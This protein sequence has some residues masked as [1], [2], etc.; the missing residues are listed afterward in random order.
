MTA[1]P[2]PVVSGSV[3][4]FRAWRVKDWQLYGTGVNRAW[5]PGVNEATC[6]PGD[7][8]LLRRYTA[9]SSHAAPHPEC[10]C[11]ITALARFQTADTHWREDHVRGAIEAWGD[12]NGEDTGFVL[13]S[14]GFRARYGRAVLLAIDPEWPPAKK[15]AVR[16]LAAEYAADVCRIE[17]LED[18]A[19]EH[20]QLVPDDLLAWAGEGQ[21]E[22]VDAFGYSSYLSTAMRNALLQNAQSSLYSA[23]MFRRCVT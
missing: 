20:G 10:M 14:T 18:A 2:E 17:H 19:K 16:A 5:V 1:E 13:H 3:I 9:W 4:G 8:P 11:G 7:D 22:E 6:D 12:R 23:G 21:P 15:A